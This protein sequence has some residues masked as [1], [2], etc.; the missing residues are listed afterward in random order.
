M[1]ATV[2]EADAVAAAEAQA[3]AEAHEAPYKALLESPELEAVKAQL[4]S[5]RL[6]YIGTDENRFRK[7]DAAYLILKNL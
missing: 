2:A 4:E 7:V 3:A 6:T 1:R 5:L